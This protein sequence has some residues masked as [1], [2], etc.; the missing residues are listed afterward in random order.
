M[1]C[2]VDHV[3]PQ[4]RAIDAFVKLIDDHAGLT[5]VLPEVGVLAPFPTV[6]V[7]LAVRAYA[8]TMYSPG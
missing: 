8:R 6:L 2:A 5:S 3:V 7:T 4:A 1:V